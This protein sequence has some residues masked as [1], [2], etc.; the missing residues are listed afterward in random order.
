MNNLKI[1]AW[2][3]RALADTDYRLADVLHEGPNISRTP[4]TQRDATDK[5]LFYVVVALA[6]LAIYL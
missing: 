3:K 5:V 2:Q 4:Q 6:L 1:D